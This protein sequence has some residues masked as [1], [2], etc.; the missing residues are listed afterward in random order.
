MAPDI[1]HAVSDAGKHYYGT[2]RA[3]DNH[4]VPRPQDPPSSGI[5][6]QRTGRGAPPRASWSSA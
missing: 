4:A 5:I 1:A 3:P 2:T 6:S